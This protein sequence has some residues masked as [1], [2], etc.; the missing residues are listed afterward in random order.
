MRG[1]PG[2]EGEYSASWNLGTSKLS[3]TRLRDTR[4]RVSRTNKARGSYRDDDERGANA[5]ALEVQG[6]KGESAN[7]S[8]YRTT[9][10]NERGWRN[11][12]PQPQTDR[13]PKT[14]RLLQ[15]GNGPGRYIIPL[16]ASAKPDAGR[17]HGGL[18]GRRTDTMQGCQRGETRRTCDLGA[19]GIRPSRGYRDPTPLGDVFGIETL[20]RTRD[21]AGACCG[22]RGGLVLRA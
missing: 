17:E 22:L 21:T 6:E 8:N 9:G 13:N 7:D 5:L 15:Q 4:T 3:R 10:A 11:P 12:K 1:K 16:L 14:D 2:K 20:R 19:S 18:T